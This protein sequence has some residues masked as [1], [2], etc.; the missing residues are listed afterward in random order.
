MPIFQSDCVFDIE[1]HD[2][3]IYLDINSLL[4]ISTPIQ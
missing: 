2:V 4:Q 3:F 1:V